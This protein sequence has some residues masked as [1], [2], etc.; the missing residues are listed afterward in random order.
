MFGPSV[1]AYV[2]WFGCTFFVEL[3]LAACVYILYHHHEYRA[4]IIE[5]TLFADPDVVKPLGAVSK[6]WRSVV[7]DAGFTSVLGWRKAP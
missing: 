1:V 3:F 6:H 2:E 5:A 7:A 4:C